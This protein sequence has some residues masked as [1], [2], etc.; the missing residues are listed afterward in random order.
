[1][2]HSLRP[3]RNID[4]GFTIAE[5]AVVV[6]LI[7]IALSMGI[8]VI[9]A[10]VNSSAITITQK[11]Q[12][13]IK[14]A[15]AAYLQQNRRLPCPDL[16]F[17]APDGLGDNN[18]TVPGNIATTC[19]AT[20]GLLPYIELGMSRDM[21]VD[22]WNNFFSYQVAVAPT[23]WTV[24][25][26]FSTQNTGNI[27]I[28]DRTPG[29]VIVP[30]M[31]NAVAAI[32]SHGP[33]GRGGYKV[34]GSRNVLPVPADELVNTNGALPPTKFQRNFTDTVTATGG[35]FDDLVLAI[36]PA[37]LLTPLLQSKAAPSYDE[38]LAQARQ[39]I[40][41]IKSALIG[42]LM[43]NSRLPNADNDGFCVALPLNNGLEDSGCFTGNIPWSTLGVPSTDP[44][45]TNYKYSV[46]QNLSLPAL[47]DVSPPTAASGTTFRGANGQLTVQDATGA[48]L[49]TTAPFVV[50]SLGRNNAAYYPNA[51]GLP[52]PCIAAAP[53]LPN[54]PVAP[55]CRGGGEVIN[56][57]PGTTTFVR[58]AVTLPNPVALVTPLMGFDDLLDWVPK[59]LLNGKLP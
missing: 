57:T 2:K 46:S 32:V 9:S 10:Q 48:T 28:N 4:Q 23:N 6:L 13:A 37:D 59:L 25:A 39:D 8:G 17:A 49:T 12:A 29:G 43:T 55:A 18:R 44:W 16:N 14:D 1:M 21:A 40:E 24:T 7:S 11:R 41:T 20:F 35:P 38:Q 22:G 56:R 26:G 36:A 51:A 54:P 19:G 3:T 27:T 50:Y 45:G 42:F 47:T 33:N 15:L 52:S 58:A 5:M 34:K 53:L 31:T 30:V